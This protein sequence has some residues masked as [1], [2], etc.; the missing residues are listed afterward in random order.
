[1]IRITR[2]LPA[3]VATV[4]LLGSGLQASAL[5][6][7][8][9]ATV[10]PDCLV[11]GQQLIITVPNL[12]SGTVMS[13]RANYTDSAPGG[14]TQ[15]ATGRANAQGVFTT[16]ITV[17]STASA[18]NG[19]LVLLLAGQ[20]EA[21]T[22]TGSFRIQTGTG[23]CPSPGLT[24]ISGSHL[25]GAVSYGVKKTCDAGVSGNAVFA[26]S[27]TLTELGRFVFPP[28]TL[29]CNGAAVTLPALPINASTVTLHE[30]TPATGATAAADTIFSLPPASIPVTIHN[31]RA[32][33]PVPPQLAGTGG[34]A[35]LE[36]AP[37]W[38]AVVALAV[39][40]AAW[41]FAGVRRNRRA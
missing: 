7:G 11:A 24:S 9:A 38:L 17:P 27:A 3:A 39:S 34:G 5:G 14:G 6:A 22:G 13:V 33:A 30:T 32:A 18:G 23:A 21:E 20:D 10:Q 1:M 25:S 35:P 29:A 4:A 40:A 16:T 37:W 15:Y 41:I 2:R 36:S 31:A 19:S 28:V 8:F 12:V 26:M